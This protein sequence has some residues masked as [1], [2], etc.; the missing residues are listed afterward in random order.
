MG[1][2]SFSAGLY[3]HTVS[4]TSL[5]EARSAACKRDTGQWSAMLWNWNYRAV[6]CAGPAGLAD[7]YPCGFCMCFCATYPGALASC[8]QGTELTAAGTTATRSLRSELCLSR[9]NNSHLK[10]C[11]VQFRNCLHLTAHHL[12]YISCPQGIS[13]SLAIKE[14]SG[15]CGFIKW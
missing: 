14:K 10:P 11:G 13:L 6:C 9:K 12:S 5:L 7:R 3:K 2:N 4:S 15:L 8:K 1:I